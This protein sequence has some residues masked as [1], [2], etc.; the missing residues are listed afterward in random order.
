MNMNKEDNDRMFAKLTKQQAAERD[1]L[2]YLEKREL[3][4]KRMDGAFIAAMIGVGLIVG[5]AC[6]SIGVDTYLKLK[7]NG[8]RNTNSIEFNLRK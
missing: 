7:N 4:E 8:Q 2:E 3:D 1:M 6:I 5:V